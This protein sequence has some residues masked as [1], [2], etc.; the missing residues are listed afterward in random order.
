MPHDNIIPD[1]TYPVLERPHFESQIP[2]HLL[3]DASASDRYIMES[4]SKLLQQSE[5]S[6]EAAMVHDQNIRLTNGRLRAVEGDVTHYKS[7]WQ[8]VTKGWKGAVMI[9]AGLSAFLALAI[10]VIKF[11]HTYA[12]VHPN[13]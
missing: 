3:K 5:W 2:E 8:S 9:A 13:P 10:H 12:L 4:L 11:L 6:T 1:S 7:N